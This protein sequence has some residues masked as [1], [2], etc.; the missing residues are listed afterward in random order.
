M[1]PLDDSYQTS[2]QTTTLINYELLLTYHKV[3]NKNIKLNALAGANTATYDLR[4]LTGATGGGLYVPNLYDLSNSVLPPYVGNGRYKRKSNALFASADITYKDF[5]GASFAMRQLWHSTLPEDDNSL[6]CPSAGI[7]FLPLNLL[8]NQPQWLSSL[9]L[10]GSW[11]S[12]PVTLGIYQT[13]T[14]FFIN[15]YP[16]NGNLMMTA[17]DVVPDKDLKGGL[18]T[19]FEAGID[20]SLFKNRVSLNANYYNET[21]SDQPVQINVDATSGLTAKYINASTVKREG[22]EFVLNATIIKGRNFSWAVT[23]PM[24]WLLKNPVTKIIEGQDRVQPSGWKSSLSRNSFASAY[25]VLGKDWGQLIG[26]G[27]ARNEEGIPLLDSNGLYLA[28]AN[29]NYG[30]IV[31]KLTGGLQSFLT[32]KS[33]F[34]NFSLDFQQGG[35]FYSCSE[36]WGNYSGTLAPTATLNDKGVNVREPVAENGGVHV[37]G[38]SALDGKTP[39]DMYVNAYAYFRQYRNTNIAEPYIHS[40]SY[41]KLRELSLGYKLPVT[42]WKFTKSYMQSAGIAFIARNPWLIYSAS[43][44]FDPSEISVVYGEEGQL[45]PTRSW[46]LNLSIIF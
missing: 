27:Y 31:P 25:Q 37:T 17:A 10:Y 33:I 26:G 9:K 41:V 23:V 35:K 11:G 15:G 46:G 18:I 45:P 1:W 28:D 34:F 19:S 39:V 44:N 7:S 40:L 2:S 24:G 32:Y 4:G 21:A 5:I 36:Y 14:S 20:F 13:N 12:T 30:S 6:F 29:Y 22:L 38:V 42:K 3:I 8:S 43:G 16:W